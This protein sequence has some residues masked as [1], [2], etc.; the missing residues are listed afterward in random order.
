MKKIYV[1]AGDYYH[2][3]ENVWAAL[4]K[5][6]AGALID[7]EIADCP[8]ENIENALEY[9]NKPDVIVMVRENRID[10]GKEDTGNWLTD[11]IDDKLKHYVEGGGALLVIHA[12]LASYAPDTEYT[13]MVKGHFVHHPNEHCAVRYISNEN[14]PFNEEAFDFELM[15]EHYFVTLLD[16]ANVFMHSHSEHGVQPAA[17]SHNYGQGK[18]LILVPTHNKKGY[19]HPEVVRLIA[20]GIKWCLNT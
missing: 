11:V 4:N 2:P 5:I 17:W 8:I 7:A 20:S 16:D 10:A 19:E 12:A 3:K 9:D 1:F 18:V 6:T 15:D 13:Q 14:M